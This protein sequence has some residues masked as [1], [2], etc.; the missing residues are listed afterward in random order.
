MAGA[1]AARQP[2][3]AFADRAIP[4]TSAP[5]TR[6]RFAPKS[7]AYAASA[8]A[9][10]A[11]PAAAPPSSA[12]SAAPPTRSASPNVFADARETAPEGIGR[13]G[14]IVASRSAS[15]TSFSTTPPAYTIAPAAATAHAAIASSRVVL[16][17]PRATRK[18]V[19]ALTAAVRAPGQRMSRRWAEIPTGSVAH[20]VDDVV[21]R[22][23]DDEAEEQH[24]T[25]PHHALEDLLGDRLPTDARSEERRG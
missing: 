23:V 17:P 2:A 10:V 1:T 3:T 20:H 4:I 25:R 15:A 14:W 6:E 12:A 24:E 13:S 22:H 8:A 5:A 19:I 7:Y 16:A 9:E 11:A 18:P 21:A